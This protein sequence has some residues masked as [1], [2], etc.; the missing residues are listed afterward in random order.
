LRRD[1]DWFEIAIVAIEVVILAG[2]GYA[3]YLLA[4]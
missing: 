2:V 1:R 4:R 3:I